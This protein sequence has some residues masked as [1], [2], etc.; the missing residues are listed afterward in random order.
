[1][2]DPNNPE[3]EIPL[4]KQFPGVGLHNPETQVEVVEPP[5]TYDPENIKQ[6]LA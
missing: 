6:K 3:P 4:D 5:E 1:V 2:V